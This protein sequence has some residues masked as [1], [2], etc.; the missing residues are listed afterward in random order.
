MNSEF[1]ENPELPWRILVV[2]DDIDAADD[3]AKL[4]NRV[5]AAGQEPYSIEAVA[6][7][8]FDK[9]LDILS[10]GGFDLLVL[11]VLDQKAAE[12]DSAGE[13]PKSR[14]RDVFEAVRS[15]RFLPIV[16]LTALPR[17]V[18]DY[19]K[20]PFVQVVSKRASNAQQELTECIKK[21]LASSFPR[22]YRDLQSHIDSVSRDFMIE[23]V[24]ENWRELENNKQD[25]AYLLMRRLGVSFDSGGDLIAS[26]NGNTPTSDD[27]VSAIRYYIV[28]PPEDYRTG[29]ILK[30][31]PSD[32]YGCDSDDQ[33]GVDINR[34]YVI[35]TPT[36]DLVQSPIK[37]DSVVVA[38]CVMINEFEE[39]AKWTASQG[40]SKNNHKRLE[41]L[42]KSNPIKGQKNR[43]FYL[44]QAWK[45]PDMM[46]DF[47]KISSIPYDKLATYNKTASLDN[48][49]AE[50]LSH[51]FHCYL[52]RV[53]TPNLDLKAA[54]FRMQS[55]T[56][57]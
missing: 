33:D 7:Q 31:A 52:G 26:R 47:Q 11:D 44:P 34:W 43:Y 55:P 2:D 37:A 5:T 4:L 1:G 42:L 21:C 10:R 51:Q 13:T 19:E 49:Y 54:I 28:P 53:G 41:R 15:T 57:V 39:H 40:G 45:L 8:S 20:A 48:P 46:V 9:A 24:E 30:L 17:A 50:S 6:E 32:D 56:N 14:G 3:T 27:A 29:D 25:F 36:C 23:F 12:A 18:K 22:I 38:E 16:F 35:M